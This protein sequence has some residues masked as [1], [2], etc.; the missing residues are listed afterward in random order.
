MPWDGSGLD[1]Q[2]DRFR[3]ILRYLQNDHA[4]SVGSLSTRFPSA[5]GATATSNW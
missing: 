2:Q 4:N 1:A 3:A 5:R